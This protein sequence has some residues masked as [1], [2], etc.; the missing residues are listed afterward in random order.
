MA[1]ESILKKLEQY[2]QFVDDIR[3]GRSVDRTRFE[4]LSQDIAKDFV[5]LKYDGDPET[6]REAES[7]IEVMG[8]RTANCSMMTIQDYIPREDPY[9]NTRSKPVPAS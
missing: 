3:T 2:S 5:R 9:L 7:R 8:D 6:F 4:A 1:D